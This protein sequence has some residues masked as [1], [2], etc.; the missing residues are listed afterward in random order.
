MLLNN[1]VSCLLNAKQITLLILVSSALPIKIDARQFY[2]IFKI[3]LFTLQKYYLP[4]GFTTW[5]LKVKNMTSVF[6]LKVY[7]VSLEN[8]RERD[9]ESMSQDSH[10]LFSLIALQFFVFLYFFRVIVFSLGLTGF[11]IMECWS[12]MRLWERSDTI[13]SFYKGAK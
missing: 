7:L 4:V 13:S 11:G 10:I 3:S 1:Q 8:Q 9:S 5:M 6:F 2:T 12:W